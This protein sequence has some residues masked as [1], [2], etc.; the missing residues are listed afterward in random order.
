M[1][2]IFTL[3]ICLIFILLCSCSAVSGIAIVGEWQS[4]DSILGVEI[5]TTYV[6]NDDGT[7]EMTTVLGL[8]QDFTYEFKGDKL[9][10]TTEILGIKNTEV[11]DY[12]FKGDVLTLEGDNSTIELTKK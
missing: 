10:I 4:D 8:S 12:T 2:R 11:Y 1:K 5:E 6:F 9:N 7:G 3:C